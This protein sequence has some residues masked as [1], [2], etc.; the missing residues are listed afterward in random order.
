MSSKDENSDWQAIASQDVLIARA[1]MLAKIRQ[2]FSNKNILEVDTPSLSKGTIT[3]IYLDALSTRS[4]HLNK[5]QTPLYLQTSPEFAMKRLLASG[6][7]SIYQ[8]CRAFRDDETGRY[9]NPEFLMLEWYRVNFNHLQLMAEMDELLVMVLD[10]EPADIITYQALFLEILGVDPLEDSNECFQKLV[11]EKANGPTLTDR[12]ELLHCLFAVL[13]EP[14][15]GKKRP[16]MVCDFPAS[17]SSLARLSKQDPRVSERFEVYYKGI[18]LANG[19]HELK[20]ADE[21]RKRFEQDNAQRLKL[22]KTQRPLDERLLAALQSGIPDCAGVA[23]GLDRLLM[24]KLNKKS[25]QEVMPFP[26][27]RA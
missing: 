26:I 11:T 21:Q 7:G 27:D 14:Q 16:L 8:I 23:L 6:M 5:G 17:Q 20:D 12:D 24:L 10:T 2:F 22:N 15:L 25:I 4:K 9:H 18:E 13:I 3:D 19:F 1:N